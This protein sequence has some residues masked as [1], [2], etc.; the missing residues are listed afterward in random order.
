[1][2]NVR[3]A[4]AARAVTAPTCSSASTR[5]AFGEAQLRGVDR[6]VAPRGPQT[7]HAQVPRRAQ[8]A[9]AGVSPAPR[10]IF[11]R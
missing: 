11:P 2:N 10:N 4:E 9:G 8:P 1:M 3:V 5:C 6:E 7:G